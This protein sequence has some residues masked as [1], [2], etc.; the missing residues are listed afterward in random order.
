LFSP[1]KIEP[2]TQKYNNIQNNTIQ[3]QKVLPKLIKDDSFN[4]S[5]KIKGIQQQDLK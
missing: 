3:Q 4:E 2:Q 5:T 1:I